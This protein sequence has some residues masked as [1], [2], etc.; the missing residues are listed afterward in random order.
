MKA[1]YMTIGTAEM[2]AGSGLNFPPAVISGPERLSATAR[3][4]IQALSGNRPTRFLSELSVTWLAIA[5]LIGIGVSM[6]NAL[7]TAI[8]VVLIGVRQMVLG[9]LLHEQ[10]HRLGLR[11]KYGDWI[12]NALAVFP[13]FAT[14]V[15]D[16]AKVHLSHHKYFMTL[17][18]PDFVRKSGAEWSFP[19]SA[20]AFIR[21]IL[22]DITGLNTLRLIKGKTGSSSQDEFLRPNPTPIW[23][24]VTYYII[25]ALALTIIGG[26]KTFLVYWLL[27]ILSVTQLCVRW[28]AVIE[29]QYNVENADVRDVTP[30]IRLKWWQRV[31]FPDLNFAMHA[32]HHYHPGVSFSN[33]PKVHEIYRREGLVNESAIFD[34]QGSFLKALIKS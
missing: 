20:W 24:R 33:L 21:I 8:C 1:T 27:P 28:T 14:T 30:L 16:Y 31:L 2:K 15:E 19:M 6:N 5:C 9:L 12:V 13:L 7:V 34:G 22:R 32:Y 11:G 26:W 29:H 10:V 17:K 18:D 3:A 25:L 4:Q 23:F